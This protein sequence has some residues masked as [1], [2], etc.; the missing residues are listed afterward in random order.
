MLSQDKLAI[1]LDRFK[2]VADVIAAERDTAIELL[3]RAERGLKDLNL[4]IEAGITLLSRRGEA[5]GTMEYKADKGVWSF[6]MNGRRVL[7][8]GNVVKV[9]AAEALEAFFESY[10]FAVQAQIRD[11]SSPYD[12]T[13]R[14]PTGD[15]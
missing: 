6:W 7:E 3:K 2:P 8:S 11:L 12:G 13:I 10:C 4:G 5:M 14:L 9:A 1:T 15:E